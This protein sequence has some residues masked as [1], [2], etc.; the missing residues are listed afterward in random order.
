MC[1]QWTAALRVSRTLP[2]APGLT[3]SNKKLL[4]TKGIATSSKDA[5]SRENTRHVLLVRY[6]G[7][8]GD[9]DEFPLST[10]GPSC[11]TVGMYVYEL[12]T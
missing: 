11:G 5:T 1:G 10:F 9:D 8:G 12:F 4:V 2:V 6:G 7:A 3:T